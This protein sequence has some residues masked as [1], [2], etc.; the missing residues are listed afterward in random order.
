[1]AK[2]LRSWG[3]LARILSFKTSL[4]C[5][6]PLF[7]CLVQ[8]L[9]RCLAPPMAEGNPGQSP[10][11]WRNLH[12]EVAIWHRGETAGKTGRA[13]DIVGREEWEYINCYSIFHGT[14]NCMISKAPRRKKFMALKTGQG[15]KCFLTS[16]SQNKLLTTL[17]K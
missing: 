4:L 2:E 1:V 13:L 17:W 6:S 10:S 9:K 12:R 7:L 3:I 16:C 8:L 5:C 14:N 15:E 11:I